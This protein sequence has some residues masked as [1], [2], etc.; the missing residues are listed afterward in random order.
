MAQNLARLGVVL[1]IDTAEF[2]TG[3]QKAKKSLS[4]IGDFAAKAGAIA[5]AAFAAMTYKAITMSD[6]IADMAKANDMAVGSILKLSGSLQ[7]SGGNAEATGKILA[8]FTN[9]VDEAAQGG[10]KAQQAFSRIG[11]GLQDLGKLSQEDLLNKTVAALAAMPDSITRNALAFELLGKGIRGTDLKELNKQLALGRDEYDKYAASIEK[12]AELNDKLYAAGRKLALSFTNEVMPA[13]VD[14]FDTINSKG[15]MADNVF[16]ILGTTIAYFNY[17]IGELGAVISSIQA[18]FNALK[19]GDIFGESGEYK[20]A[21]NQIA[22]DALTRMDKLKEALRDKSQDKAKPQ[23]PVGRMVTPAKDTELDKEKEMLRVAGLINKEYERERVFSLRQL[24]IRGQMAGMTTNER[25]IQEAINQQLDAT[26]KKLQDITNKR[27]DAAGRGASAKVLAVYDA[28][29]E[30]VQRNSEQYINY[31]RRIEEE[32]IATQRTFEYGWDKAFNQFAENAYN[33]ARVAEEMFNS[34]TSNMNSAIDNFV[35]TGK[36]SFSSFAESVI[37][38]I[39]KIQLRMQAS[40]LLQ[41]GIKFAM[42]AFGGGGPEP[43]GNAGGAGFPGRASG[44][45]VS[46]NAPYMVGERGPELFVPQRSGT[47]IPNHQLSTALGGGGTTFNGPYIAN[48]QAIDTQSGIQFLA[49]NK[50]TIWSMNQSANR[51]IPAGR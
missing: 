23:T 9:K 35:E 42:S 29:F 43:L 12:A 1:G 26:S 5:G 51:S 2:T 36:L 45:S 20:N 4:E 22:L 50:M 11:I 27:E 31:A 37:K 39:I 21:M 34:L 30:A 33:Y 49:K 46:E 3:L 25:S 47:I 15:G 16:K 32:T 41:M 44:G 10:L 7:L 40:Q 48:M 8:S 28:Q 13:V 38:D 19:K 6:E 14:L 18:K 17:G 24:Q